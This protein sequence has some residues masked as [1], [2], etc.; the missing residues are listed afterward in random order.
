MNSKLGQYEKIAEDLAEQGYSVV[1]KFLSKGEVNRLLQLEVFRMG[2]S[3]FKKAAVGKTERK[4]NENIRGDLIQWIDRATADPIL[5]IYLDRLA[6]LIP[7][8]NQNLFLSLKDFEMH[9]TIYPAGGYYQRHLDQFKR[10]DHRKLSVIFYLNE[11]WQVEHGG[12]LRMHLPGGPL[13]IFPVAGRFICFRSD[14][15]EHEVLPSSRERLSLTGWILDQ[16]AELRHL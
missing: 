3:H 1:D 4:I 8:L 5:R 10:D 14:K 2:L 13:D 12:Q 6:E 15:I 7:Y 9:L 11:N 16:L